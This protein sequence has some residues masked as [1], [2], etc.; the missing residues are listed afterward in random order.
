[1]SGFTC[2]SAAEAKAM[3]DS[4]TPT[5]V[6][7]RDAQSYNASHIDTAIL[8]DNNS[9]DSFIDTT[10]K[11][12]PIIVYCFHGMR[13]QNVANFLVEKEFTN[14][15]SMDGGYEFWRIQY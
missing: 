15:Y 11:D 1:M 14:I 3:I 6:D 9:V 2:I 12:T 4:G 13:S 7:V 5:L 8:L 10:A